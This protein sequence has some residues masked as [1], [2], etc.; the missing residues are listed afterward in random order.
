VEKCGAEW[1]VLITRYYAGDQIEKHEV[2]GA[3]S[4]CGERR[5]VIRKRDHLENP[6]FKWKDNIKKDPQEVGC[7]M[8][9][10]GLDR[11]GSG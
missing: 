3:C 7:W 11:A 6:K 9:G 10:H 8:W 4:T 5:S 2:V 1:S